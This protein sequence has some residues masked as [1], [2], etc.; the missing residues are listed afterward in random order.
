MLGKRKNC[1]TPMQSNHL[2]GGKNYSGTKI[3]KKKFIL[4][5]RQSISKI[6]IEF[7]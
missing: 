5:E 1:F 6:S 3:K 7:N 2:K 4:E